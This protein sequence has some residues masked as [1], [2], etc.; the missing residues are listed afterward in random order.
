[1]DFNDSRRKL[2]NR[3]FFVE[4]QPGVFVPCKKFRDKN[5]FVPPVEDKDINSFCWKL[6]ADIDQFIETPF[7]SRQN[8]SNIKR[9]EL[10]RN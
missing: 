9:N 6:R 10:S 2:N 3:A 5:S 7:T 4:A 1:M 8:L